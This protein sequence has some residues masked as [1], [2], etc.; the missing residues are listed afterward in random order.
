MYK[1]Y[2]ADLIKTL[3]TSDYQEALRFSNNGEF[4]IEVV[5]NTSYDYWR[6]K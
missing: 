2:R 4:P 6:F 3:V 5:T 1:V